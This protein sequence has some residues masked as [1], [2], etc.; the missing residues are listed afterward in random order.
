ML[1]QEWLVNMGPG[2]RASETKMSYNSAN[3]CSIYKWH[4]KHLALYNK[5][6]YIFQVL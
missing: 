3:G 4:L 6:T 1:D 5:H 2:K